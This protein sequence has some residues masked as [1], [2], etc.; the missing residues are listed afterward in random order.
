MPQ[1]ALGVA[2]AQVAGRTWIMGEDFSLAD[3]AAAPA[4]FYA[5]KVMPFANAYPQTH[6]YLRRL[7]KRPSYLCT[8]KEAKPYFGMFP[9]DDG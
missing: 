8:L 7:M 4:L 1:K 2:E 5:D 9:A 3:C 6:A